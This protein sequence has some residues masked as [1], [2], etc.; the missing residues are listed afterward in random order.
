[1]AHITRTSPTTKGTEFGRIVFLS[2]SE[3]LLFEHFFGAGNS[4]TTALGSSASIHQGHG[5]GGTETPK[6]S[7]R[8]VMT[9]SDGLL[10]E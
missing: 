10:K 6:H 2:N 1:M 9:Y 3:L 8:T 7:S 5:H 4:Q